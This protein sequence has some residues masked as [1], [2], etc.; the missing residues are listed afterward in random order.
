VTGSGAAGIRI[1]VA[2]ISMSYCGECRT[3]DKL[4]QVLES[5]VE[6]THVASGNVSQCRRDIRL[7]FLMLCNLQLL[8]IVATRN[9]DVSFL[10]LF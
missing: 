2:G 7:Y 10:G 9:D 4:K 5:A 6:I 3:R 8:T 1:D